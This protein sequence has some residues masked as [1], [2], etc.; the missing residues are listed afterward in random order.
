MHDLD[1]WKFVRPLKSSGDLPWRVPSGF[2]LSLQDRL[3]RSQR[4][5][6]LCFLK[7]KWTPNPITLEFNWI[8]PEN[9]Q[10]IKSACIPRVNPQ[11]WPP[12]QQRPPPSASPAPPNLDSASTNN[13][14]YLRRWYTVLL[15]WHILQWWKRAVVQ[16]GVNN[17]TECALKD[18]LEEDTTIRQ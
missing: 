2:R 5:P 18:F 16:C 9:G 3:T 7:N 4:P 13:G 6:P 1:L 17:R 12:P 14:V 11:P 10:A 15:F 8:E